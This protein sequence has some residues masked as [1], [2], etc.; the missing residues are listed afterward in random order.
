MADYKYLPLLTDMQMKITESI[1]S[2]M[3]DDGK[4]EETLPIQII[5]E[6]TS[7]PQIT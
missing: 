2:F 6:I 7:L 1:I 4:M 5:Y 3:Y